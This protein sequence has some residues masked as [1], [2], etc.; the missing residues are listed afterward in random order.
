MVTHIYTNGQMYTY[1][2][3]YGVHRKTELYCLASDMDNVPTAVPN[4]T[5]LYIMDWNQLTSEEQLALG[6]QVHMF[7]AENQRWIPQ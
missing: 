5:T 2:S 7:D 6:G 1:G 4:A 3:D